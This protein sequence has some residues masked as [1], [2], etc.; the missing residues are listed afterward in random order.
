MSKDKAYA[1]RN[2]MKLNSVLKHLYSLRYN[3]AADKE[4]QDKII[5]AINIIKEVEGKAKKDLE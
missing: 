5:E 3:Y 2:W 4:K 1:Q